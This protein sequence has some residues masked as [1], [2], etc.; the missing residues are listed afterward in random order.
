MSAVRVVQ[1]RN[2]LCSTE[3]GFQLGNAQAQIS[4]A[5]LHM[6]DD[7]RGAHASKH[8]NDRGN[9]TQ[10]SCKLRIHWHK[11]G[12]TVSLLRV[13][14]LLQG[15]KA[16]FCI[17]LIIQR[18]RRDRDRTFDDSS[19]G[20][21][22]GCSWSREPNVLSCDGAARVSIQGTACTRQVLQHK[23]QLDASR[24]F[25]TQLCMNHAELSASR[26][27]GCAPKLHELPLLDPVLSC[28]LSVALPPL[29]FFLGHGF[30]CACLHL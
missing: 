19:P 7:S 20:E 18:G 3:L 23:L 24:S 15:C 21:W 17:F 14:Q 11:T 16:R 2:M 22:C 4:Y 8:K 12:K 25:V 1:G 26:L 5:L 27:C 9:N 6:K 30:L 13:E 29:H 10:H 28:A